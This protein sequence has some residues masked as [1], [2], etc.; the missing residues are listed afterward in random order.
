MRSVVTSWPPAP[1]P[2][3]STSDPGQGHTLLKLL[4]ANDWEGPFLPSGKPWA[5]FALGHPDGLAKTFSELIQSEP[6]SIQSCFLPSLPSQLSVFH[7][8]RG[9]FPP[10]P[11]PVPISFRGLSPS[12]S[13]G[14]PTPP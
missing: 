13:I 14:C 8:S 11:A 9:L 6:L 4:P 3:G 10:A 12:E 5:A 7:T 2:S 1:G